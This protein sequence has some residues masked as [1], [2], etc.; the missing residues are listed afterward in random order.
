LRISGR[1]IVATPAPVVFATHPFGWV[2]HIAHVHGV[3]GSGQG[4]AGDRGEQRCNDCFHRVLDVFFD[5][6]NDVVSGR[7]LFVC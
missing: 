7:R 5:D 3:G 1:R 2:H 4:Q 6:V